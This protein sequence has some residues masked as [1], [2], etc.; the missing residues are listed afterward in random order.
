MVKHTHAQTISVHIVCVHAQRG[1]QPYLVLAGLPSDFWDSPS[2]RPPWGTAPSA[3][4][5][6]ISVTAG[7]NAQSPSQEVPERTTLQQTKTVWIIYFKNWHPRV[8]FE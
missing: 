2:L 7:G 8:H 3:A 1:H 6:C 5:G 4:T